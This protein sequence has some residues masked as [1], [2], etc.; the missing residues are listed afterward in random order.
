MAILKKLLIEDKSQ[1]EDHISN[2][3][4]GLEYDSIKSDIQRAQDKWLKNSLSLPLL[5]KL[6]EAYDQDDES[7]LSSSASSFS[8]YS[9]VYYEDA[10]YLSQQALAYFA[11]SLYIN[12]AFAAVSNTNIHT[13]AI[14]GTQP[15]TYFERQ[16][17][18]QTYLEQA[19]ELLDNLYAY[20]ELNI[21]AF[22][23]WEN[24]KAYTEYHS[25]FIKT[26]SEFSELVNINDSR[27]TF[28]LLRTEME[29]IEG[30]TLTN[31]LSAALIAE[32]K[33]ELAKAEPS[34]KFVTLNGYLKRHIANASIVRLMKSHLV[35]ID[36]QAIIQIETA[37]DHI[38][39]KYQADRADVSAKAAF[40]QS[41]A[42]EWLNEA[43]KYLN[44]N[45]S[46]FTNYTADDA[47]TWTR[48][49][50][51]NQTGKTIGF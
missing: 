15:L 31:Y 50:L 27:R 5:T 2:L 18:S 34:P 33:A 43:K 8:L 51:A 44:A 36:A 22:P 24:S 29:Y 47:S 48:N 17:L 6:C 45:A 19:L 32:I 39:K 3:Q 35:K 42:D 1:L 37:G 46:S 49:D 30:I 16:E 10:K 20:L 12:R 7:S 9:E 25:L 40:H 14:E 38:D 21:D 4:S 11:Y 28:K 26:A 23:E 41:A 13:K